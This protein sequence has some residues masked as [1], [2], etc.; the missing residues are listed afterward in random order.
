MYSRTDAEV[1]ASV[2]VVLRAEHIAVS[3]YEGR[4]GCFR[5]LTARIRQPA[6]AQRYAA[7]CRKR[8]LD[9]G[10]LDSDI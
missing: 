5:H 10:H 1:P 7:G 9:Y 6:Q 3:D 2:M 4:Q 8:V